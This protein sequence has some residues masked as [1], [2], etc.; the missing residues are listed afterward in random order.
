MTDAPSLTFR[1]I[2]R[3]L[4]KARVAT[5]CQRAVLDVLPVAAL[6]LG[7]M[8]GGLAVSHALL[9]DAPT[10]PVLS[11]TAGVSALLLLGLWRLAQRGAFS[12]RHAHPL[13]LALVLVVL[14]NSALHLYLTRDI[15]HSTNFMLLITG[16]GFLLLVPAWYA[17]A[18]SLTLA[19]WAGLVIGI[20]ASG[21]TLHYL[22]AVGMASIL[23]VVVLIGR[24]RLTVRLEAFRYQDEQ[25][26]EM[27]RASLQASRASE[28]TLSRLI[29]ATRLLAQPMGREALLD[30]VLERLKTL[31]PYDNA[32]L[33]LGGS[34]VM[35]LEAWR[36]AV[37]PPA[38]AQ[39]K[40]YL[41]DNPILQEVFHGRKPVLVNL[42]PLPAYW[43]TVISDPACQSWLVAP[44]FSGGTAVGLLILGSRKQMQY[45]AEELRLLSA[46]AD[47]AAA[48]IHNTLLVNWT[49]QALARLSFLYEATRT[50]STILD[51]N[52]ILETL[53]TLAYE[54]IR[55]E[56]ISI[57]LAQPDGSLVFKAAAGGAGDKIIGMRVP[58]GRGLVG[59]VAQQGEP[60][61]VPDVANDPRFYG[62]VDK[63]TGFATQ[64][65]YALPVW[66][67]DEVIAV[68]EMINPRPETDITELRD[69]ML[70]LAS[71]AAS[72]LHNA[73][74]F[75]Q[76]RRAE[77]RYQNL[78]DMNIAPVLVFDGQGRL[79][80]ANLAARNLFGATLQKGDEIF[81]VL[82]LTSERFFQLAAELAAGQQPVWEFSLS[83]PQGVR[84]LECHLTYL[85]DY[86]GQDVYQWMGHDVTE[87]VQL[88]EM[89]SR[90]NHMIV[91][92]L[93]NPLGVIRTSLDMLAECASG[94]Y[95]QWQGAMELARRSLNRMSDMIENMLD[96]ARMTQGKTNLI[97]EPV[98]LAEL[99][100]DVNDAVQ[101]AAMY[102]RQQIV[103]EVD[104]TRPELMANRS[105][106]RRIL[107]NLLDNAI[108]F[109]PAGTTI[110][111]RVD[112]DEAAGA[113]RFAVSDQGPGV[114][115]EEREAIFDAYVRGRAQKHEKGVGLGLAFCK[116]AVEAHGGRIWVESQPGHG[117]TFIFTLP[118]H[119]SAG[120]KSA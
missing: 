68:L 41:G 65:I 13:S 33:L 21:D 31:L 77:Q 46:F 51:T 92:D 8:Y 78:F 120:E 26:E 34:D 7:M 76:V 90:L 71:L 57:A 9:L 111:L 4:S 67:G 112:E 16:T 115:S 119:P 38:G 80:E 42:Q 114:P 18:L 10:G 87:R 108:K 66:M 91:H 79:L 69:T 72:A 53:M 101:H 23:S 37:E 30:W 24:Y 73:R 56:A 36:G 58:K 104:S 84:V 28:A 43:L 63:Q 12:L 70:A 97:L 82:Q 40:V 95:G 55:P 61:W 89:R 19:V 86:G 107:V 49:Q 105:Y 5:A 20:G 59:W 64:S 3:R 118:F 99:L 50:L 102:R 52:K 44:L 113:W 25:R 116:L 62:V 83:T 17:A 110:R 81:P 93:R 88:E 11:V 75:E 48:A 96:T 94:D 27:L 103:M 98:I 54:Q 29:E 22:Y 35:T 15:K 100:K 6:I 1:E 45:G 47:Y 109:S 2:R 85:R 106:L 14:I 39:M 60:V 74:L 117:A 32:V